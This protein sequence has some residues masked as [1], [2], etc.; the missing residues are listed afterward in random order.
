MAIII[1]NKEFTDGMNNRDGTNKDA[2]RLCK[3][4]EWLGFSTKRH[5]NLMG[6]EMRSS[7]QVREH[8]SGKRMQPETV[9]S[10]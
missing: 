7:L 4:F 6:E 8:D 10:R 5:D 3:L 2:E 9:T 1:N